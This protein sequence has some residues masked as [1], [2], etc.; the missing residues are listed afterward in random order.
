M[1][2]YE[3]LFASQALALVATGVATVALSLLAYEL[4]GEDAGAVLGTA[5]AVKMLVNVTIGPLATSLV[6]GLPRGSV[7]AAMSLTRVAT[8]LALP[9]VSAAW[10]VWLLI[11]TFQVGAAVAAAV[12]IATVDEML[13]D[14]DDFARAIAKSRIA[15]E[16]ETLLSPLLAA[17][18]LAVIAPHDTFVACAAL[19]GLA[20]LAM[21]G[22]RFPSGHQAT[23]D[24]TLRFGR[25][26][27]LLLADRALRAAL[28]LSAAGITVSAMIVVNTV[29]LVR[30][31]L[32]LDGVFVG[33][34][35]AA[36]GGGGMAAALAIPTLMQRMTEIE[37][38]KRSGM[39]V[40]VLLLLGPL[41]ASFPALVALWAA[42]GIAST[43][44]QL[45]V[46][47]MVGRLRPEGGRQTVHAA[48][49]ALDHAILMVAYPAAGWVGAIAGLEYS[50]FGLA[51]LACLLVLT[52]ALT[53]KDPTSARRAR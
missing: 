24:P 1:A 31:I 9:F 17:V 25:S 51:A 48:H 8:L 37:L 10:H 21:R 33:L 18:L 4:A 15:Y 29:A 5:L 44:T 38:M 40:V 20:M 36:Y 22:V 43:L 14:D 35:L 42:I 52:A 16:A 50:F 26:L 13:P 23:G 53:S 27:R 46:K 45:P 7:L 34:A 12:Y 19:L 2:S 30:G 49:Y 41:A 32:E 6:V 47:L 11:G 39:V 28:V 3:R